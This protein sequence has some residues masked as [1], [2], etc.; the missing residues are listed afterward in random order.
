[1]DRNATPGT[2]PDDLQLT[3]DALQLLVEARSESDRLGHPFIGTEHLVLALTQQTDGTAAATLAN[4]GIDREQVR[5]TISGMIVSGGLDPAPGTERPYTTRTMAS[6]SFAAECAR[7]L[8]H[9]RVG[10]AHMLV[11]LMR[12]RMNIGAQVLHRHGLTAESAVAEIQ[13][14]ST[15]GGSS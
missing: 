8:G 2:H 13:R 14:R 7:E 12:E 11:G 4:L 1:M 3:D 6:F 15:E 10:A 5:Q 9:T